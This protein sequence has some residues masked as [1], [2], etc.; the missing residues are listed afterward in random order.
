MR[1]LAVI[2]LL[3]LAYYG[4]ETALAAAP[5]W[6]DAMRE[7]LRQ[8]GRLLAR[9]GLDSGRRQEA[10]ETARDTSAAVRNCSARRSTCRNN[11]AP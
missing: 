10:G 5:R 8:A 4:V 1:A 11:C 7:R 6:D 3:I 2:A 9:L